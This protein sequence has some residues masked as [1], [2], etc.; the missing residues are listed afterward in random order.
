MKTFPLSFIFCYPTLWIRPRKSRIMHTVDYL[1]KKKQNKTQ[2][3]TTTLICAFKN[4]F[5]PAK[6]NDGETDLVP[7]PIIL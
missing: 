1:K 5:V 3:T 7:F 6:P 2:S 4:A